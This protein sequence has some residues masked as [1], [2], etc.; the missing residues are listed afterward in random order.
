[1]KAQMDT[2]EFIDR[3]AHKQR[4]K[5]RQAGMQT[6]RHAQTVA[7]RCGQAKMGTD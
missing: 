6:G 4:G 2:E 3:S 7:D 1:M 5:A